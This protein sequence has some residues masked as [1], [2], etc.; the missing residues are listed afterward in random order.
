[1][2]KALV[3]LLSVVCLFGLTLTA[4]N[5]EPE[6]A[7]MPEIPEDAHVLIAYFTWSSNTERLAEYLADKTDGVLYEIEPA[8]PY[9]T[10]YTRCTEVALEERDSDAR[11]EIKNP[12]D[13]SQFDVIFIGYPIWWWTAPMIIGTFLESNDL[14]GK[15]IYPFS[16]SASM[17]TEQFETSMDFVRGCAGTATVHDGLFARAT[18]TAT[19]DAYLEANG[20]TVN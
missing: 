1:M 15:D 10:D 3:F 11:P 4:C 16:Q 14:T 2:K 20:F 6:G 5:N 9:P 12:I 13:V 19:I 7:G 17:N 8:T 18:S